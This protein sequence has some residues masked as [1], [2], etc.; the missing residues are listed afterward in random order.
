MTAEQQLPRLEGHVLELLEQ[1]GGSVRF[2]EIRFQLR[3]RGRGTTDT[4]L[5]D[6]L[7]DLERAGEIQPTHWQRTP[8][9]T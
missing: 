6:A 2:D 9:T 1:A 8:A 3:R 5:V 7:W 4:E